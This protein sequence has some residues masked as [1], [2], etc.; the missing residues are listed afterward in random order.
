MNLKRRLSALEGE[1]SYLTIGEL[2][3]SLGGVPLPANKG[4]SPMTAK[5]LEAM[6]R[7]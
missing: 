7:A 6:P 1:G 5:A 4:V 2:L 3:D